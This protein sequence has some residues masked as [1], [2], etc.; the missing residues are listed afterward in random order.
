MVVEIVPSDRGE[1]EFALEEFDPHPTSFRQ[2]GIVDQ[3]SRTE[4]DR[5]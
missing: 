1:M 3:S 5:Q 2:E 4:P